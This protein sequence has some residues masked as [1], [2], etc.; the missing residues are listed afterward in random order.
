MWIRAK[1]EDHSSGSPLIE[2]DG[3]KGLWIEKNDMWSKYLRR[4]MDTLS[5]ICFAQF[6]KMYT[7]I[8][9]GDTENK[10]DGDDELATLNDI[11]EKTIIKVSNR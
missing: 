5:D 9:K 3:R 1:P 8:K 10:D 6:A 2:L 4:P 11:Q 7:S